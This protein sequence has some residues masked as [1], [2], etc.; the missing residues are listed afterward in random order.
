MKSLRGGK[1]SII[2]FNKNAFVF[3]VV[4]VACGLLRVILILLKQDVPV[5]QSKQQTGKT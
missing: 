1:T 4:K 5:V 3:R 2:N